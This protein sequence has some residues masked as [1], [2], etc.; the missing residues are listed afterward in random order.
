LLCKRA[1]Q[2]LARAS[3]G[4]EAHALG[5]R[6]GT[7]MPWAARVGGRVFEEGVLPAVWLGALGRVA[8]SVEHD[9]R[10]SA[11]DLARRGEDVDVVAIGEDLARA[12]E[13]AVERP[14]D[15]DIEAA[16]VAR[17][18]G[19]AAGLGGEMDVVA[20]NRPVHDGKALRHRLRHRLANR[21]GLNFGA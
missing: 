8:A 11:A 20:L 5:D 1:I 12:A 17:E 15:A 13:D 7:Q 21:L 10:A 18:S 14:R 19:G 3:A 6:A 2:L 4:A 9:V 16:H